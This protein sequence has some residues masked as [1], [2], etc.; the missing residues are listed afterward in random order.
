MEDEG[1]IMEAAFASGI[2]CD[3]MIPSYNEAI[4]MQARLKRYIKGMNEVY[5]GRDN[6]Q[7]E[8]LNV[9]LLKPRT[10]RFEYAGKI[11][12]RPVSQTGGASDLLGS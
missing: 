9:T 5:A 10:L 12:M 3:F 4:S 2:P 8:N 11:K 7:F 1:A 6:N